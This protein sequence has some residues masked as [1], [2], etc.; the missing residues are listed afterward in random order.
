MTF[1]EVPHELTHTRPRAAAL[2]FPMRIRTIKPEFF[3]HDGIA[4]LAPLTR[5]L[6]IGLWSLADADGR[7]EDRPARIRVEILPYDDCDPEAMLADLH[8]AGF[9]RR[10][11]IDGLALIELPSFRRHQ[12]I[13]GKEAQ[14][15]SRF[16]KYVDNQQG[17]HPGSTGEAPGKHL[18]AQETEGKGRETEGKGNNVAAVAAEVSFPGNLDTPSFRSAWA[19]WVAY[20]KERKL[21]AYKPAT[22][23]A[24]LAKLAEWGE[25]AAVDAIRESIRQNWQGI[26]EPKAGP[27]GGKRPAKLGTDM[28]HDDLKRRHGGTF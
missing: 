7:M 5:L 11:Q 12:R 18:A 13:G 1:S 3:K 15:P 20:R 23:R 8:A 24:Q 16:P 19:E 6:F 9:I 25:G 10:Y 21:A 26:F 22:I 17:K 14:Q 2:L 28:A 27:G 4:A